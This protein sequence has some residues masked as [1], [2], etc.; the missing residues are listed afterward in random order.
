MSK[1]HTASR[2]RTYG[3]RQHELHERIDRVTER[4]RT[5][6]RLAQP[7]TTSGSIPV[8]YIDAPGT[9]PALRLRR[10]DGRLPGRPP[11]RAAAA[12]PR[13]ASPARSRGARSSDAAGRAGQRRS[14]PH[15]G[16]R[17]RAAAR[18]IARAPAVVD[19]ARPRGDRDR[20]QRRVPVAEPE[21]PRRGDRLR[22]RP[23][24][25]R[26]RSA[27]RRSA[28]TSSPTWSGCAASR[29]SASRRSMPASASSARRSSS[30]PASE[31]PSSA[32][33]NRFGAPPA[34]APDRVRRSPRARSSSA[35]ATGS[36]VSA[37][38]SSRARAARST[39]GPR[40]R[41][42]RGQIYDR[43]GTVV[44]A[45]SVIRDRLIVSAEHMNEAE[46]AEM[47]AFLTA[48]LGLDAAAAALAAKLAEP[49]PYLV[50]AR[51]LAP[52][53]SDGDRGRGAA[54]GIDGITFESDSSAATR[55]PAAAR[56]APSPATSSAS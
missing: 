15:A 26:A 31:R 2:R 35:S 9:E 38:S 24:R 53:R 34:P 13:R 45:A 30:P 40:S 56:T 5:G 3:R 46:R 14:R 41:A 19:R 37:T 21:R 16:R 4:R 22:H 39:T 20:V 25:L 1:R 17:R 36:S 10:T 8:G 18:P 51:D 29:P 6:P 47:V 23:A 43:S 55:R 50:I 28:R 27:R 48:Q 11:P 12:R 42:E 52:E 44:L 54:A 33:S 49:K 32:R 7:A